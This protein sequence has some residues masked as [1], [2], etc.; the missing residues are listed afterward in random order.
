MM[1][2]FKSDD[3]FNNEGLDFT[4]TLVPASD[5]PTLVEGTATQAAAGNE[6]YLPDGR[7]L[8]GAPA[9]GTL[10]LQHGRKVIQTD[11]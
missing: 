2:F 11:K 3:C 1:I 10:Y 8:Q 7:R 5:A 4:V 9:A 6:W